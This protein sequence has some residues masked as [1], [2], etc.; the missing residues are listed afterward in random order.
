MVASTENSARLLQAASLTQVT[1]Q[2]SHPYY[3]DIRWFRA[4]YET[5]DSYAKEIEKFSGKP[6]HAYESQWLLQAKLREA[7]MEYKNVSR[8]RNLFQLVTNKQFV[9]WSLLQDLDSLPQQEQED[10]K[11]SDVR[12]C[13]EEIQRMEG[14]WEE[15]YGAGTL[16]PY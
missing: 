2:S 10:P 14:I 5:T 6:I 16:G 8:I 4:M 7:A 15:M 3:G 12:R 1:P 9:S 11:I 13:L